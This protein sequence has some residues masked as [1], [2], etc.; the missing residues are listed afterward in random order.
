MPL[1]HLTVSGHDALSLVDPSPV[2][3]PDG[4]ILLYYFMSYQN[5]G[6]PAL[7]LGQ[8]GA[9]S[10]PGLVKDRTGVLRIYVVGF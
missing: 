2:L 9:G 3:M 4:T 8:V 6:D 1:W 7:T 10:V 5:S